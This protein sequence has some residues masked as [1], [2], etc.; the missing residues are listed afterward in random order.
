MSAAMV[1]ARAAQVLGQVLP[2]LDPQSK[3]AIAAGGQRALSDVL[4]AAQNAIPEADRKLMQELCFGTCRWHSRLDKMLQSL[5]EHPIKARDTDIHALLLVGLYQL[6]YMRIA[7]HAAVSETAEAARVLNKPWAVGLV[8]GVLRAAMRT[9]DSLEAGLP[10]SIALRTAH[11]QW[12]VSLLTEAWPD[13]AAA[14]LEANNLQAP[15]TLRVNRRRCTRD[16]YLT[17]LADAGIEAQ[18]CALS[19]D[20][21]RL[22]RPA[23]VPALPGYA[24]GWFSVQDEAAQLAATLLAPQ[25][26]ERILDACAAPGG[27]TTHLLESADIDCVALDSDARRCERIH[28]NLARLGLTADVQALSLEDYAAANPESRFD[29]ILLDVPCSAT[30]II[31]RHP[32]I[33]WLRRKQDILTLAAQQ[34]RLLEV[35]FGLLKPGGR[36]L[37]ATC[38]V[39]PQENDRVIAEFLHSQDNAAPLALPAWVPGNREG[40]CQLFPQV[41]GHDGFYYA[42]LSKN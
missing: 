8:N 2:L 9:R 36:L 14:L 12:L 37:Y 40:R 27:K 24:E 16:A 41:N 17:H 35:A 11:P 20:G 1:R 3:A 38:S 31:R 25:A 10:D 34:R 33:K 4:P 26:G 32:D 5:L 29:R 39:L 18:A 21:I 42:L 15:L 23:L 6:W 28:E 22:A 7:P 13:D 30:G 19:A